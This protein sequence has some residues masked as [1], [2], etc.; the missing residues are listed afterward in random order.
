[1][2]RVCVLGH[3]GMLGHVVTRFLREAGCHVVTIENR[4][5]VGSADEGGEWL[6]AVVGAAADWYVNCIGVR[7]GGGVSERQ[8]DRVNHQLP[9]LCSRYLPEG[10]GFIHASSDGVF[11]PLSGPCAWDRPRDAVDPYG[12]SKTRA[13]MSLGRDNDFIIRCSIVGPERSTSRSLLAWLA[14]QSGPVDGFTNQSWNGITT[15]AWA[16]IC[17]E[18]IQGNQLG[19]GRILQPASTPTVSK[20][21]LLALLTEIWGLSTAV[22]LV[23]G[24]VEVTRFL[25]PNLPSVPLRDQLAELRLWY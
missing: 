8:L 6:D 25:L 22:N 2:I 14:Q 7:P 15:L 12:R 21:E 5:G 10:S 1:M 4:F 11:S 16:K 20:G 3:R 9:S 17:S 18:I 19:E 23:E 13:E 24:A